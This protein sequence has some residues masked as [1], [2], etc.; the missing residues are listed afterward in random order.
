M[1]SYGGPKPAATVIQKVADLPRRS[2]M[3]R[4]NLP[5]ARQNLIELLKVAD[6]HSAVRRN[7]DGGGVGRLPQAC[8]QRVGFAHAV[9]VVRGT[10]FHHHD[11][12]QAI[13]GGR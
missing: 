9:K 8:E 2:G 6:G 5:I 1:I 4:R 11:L 10:A 7:G 12:L 13:G 3:Q